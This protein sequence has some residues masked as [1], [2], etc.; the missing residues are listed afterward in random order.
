VA[1]PTDPDTQEVFRMIENIP[2]KESR[3]IGVIS[4][5]DRKQEG[6]DNWVSDF[7]RA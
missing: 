3:V 4:K 2:D 5:C 6:A 7:Q 1:H